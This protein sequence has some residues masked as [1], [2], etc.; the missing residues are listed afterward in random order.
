MKQ[1]ITI[2][3]NLWVICA[4]LVITNLL[5]IVMWQPWTNGSRAS[6]TITVTGTTTI[7]SAPDKFVFTPYYQK[8]GTNKIAINKELSDLAKT[9][10][11]NLISL[12]VDESAIKSEVSSYDY[13]I[14]KS[15]S[16]E[17]TSANLNLTIN[18]RDKTLAQKVQDYITTTSPSGSIT[19]QVSF[20]D[21]KQRILESSARTAALK[22]AKTKAV[23]SAKQLDANLG[24]AVSVS[25][26]NS[27]GV[28]PL[29]WLY[30]TDD[31]AVSPSSI[32]ST[33][34]SYRILTG[35]NEYTFSV[36]VTYEL[37]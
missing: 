36:E 14:Y 5:T 33:G 37:K 19:P 20:S 8:Q 17:E 10:T 11:D 1:T 2:K 27:S 22:D 12:G 29:P 16:G 3:L 34:S 24:K 31:K 28:T 35:M 4:V 9:I 7:E 23:A 25:D 18:V 30:G 32:E 21:S 13:E 15:G 6:R 26:L